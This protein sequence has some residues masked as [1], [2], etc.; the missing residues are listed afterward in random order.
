MDNK[1]ARGRFYT[2]GN[3]FKL[4][5]FKN[6]AYKANIEEKTILEPFAGAKDIPN[7]IDSAKLKYRDWKLYDIHPGANGI[8]NGTR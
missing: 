8:Q 1:R 6:W 5:P 4:H 7:L 2:R 3:P